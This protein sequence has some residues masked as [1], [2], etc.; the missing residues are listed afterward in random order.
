MDSRV[1]YF[2]QFD[3]DVFFGLTFYIGHDKLD[4]QQYAED[5]YNL[6]IDGNRFY[7]LMTQEKIER[8]SFIKQKEREYQK[9]KKMEDDYYKRA[10]KYNGKDY[11][12]FA[13][14]YSRYCLRLA[15][16]SYFELK[17]LYEKTSK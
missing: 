7:D 12:V 8:Q 15:V 1:I 16:L 5:K 14:P 6:F 13:S 2:N 4:L 17:R 10:L 3:S 11:Y 9:R